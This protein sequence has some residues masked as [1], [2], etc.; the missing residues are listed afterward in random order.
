MYFLLQ[1]S[2]YIK[3]AKEKQKERMILDRRFKIGWNRW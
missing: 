3:L 2:Y 1:V